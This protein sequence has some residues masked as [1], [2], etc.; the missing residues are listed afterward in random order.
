MIAEWERT[1]F[2][3][4]W[5][6]RALTE[7]FHSSV[8]IG[9]LALLDGRPAAYLIA[10]LGFGQGEVLRIGTSAEYRRRGLG[11]ALL[12]RFFADAAAAECEAVFLEVRRGNEAARALYEAAGF[13]GVGER[14]GYYS[15]PRED[16]ILYQKKL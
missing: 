15:A 2:S 4:P 1:L 3:D 14:R 7:H 11:Q 16:A 6:Q 5:S 12:E 8:G 9:Y 10:S 13:L